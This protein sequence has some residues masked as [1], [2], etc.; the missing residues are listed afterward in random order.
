MQRNWQRLAC[1]LLLSCTS[2]CLFVQHKTRVV[3]D[4]EALRPVQFESDQACSVFEA[5]VHE[6]QANKQSTDADVLAI[7]FVCVYSRTNVLSDNAIY[8]DQESA[9][10]TDGD[11]T[12][13]L[14]EA[15]DYRAR[16]TERMAT[17]GK[18][19]PVKV[20]IANHDKVG[21]DGSI[22]LR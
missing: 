21:P 9:S 14:Q 11:N 3:R 16:V 10:D 12:I 17:A 13:T 2:G 5:G 7:P 1:A 6:L 22:P 19:T 20:D 8:N 18:S 4:K 15:L